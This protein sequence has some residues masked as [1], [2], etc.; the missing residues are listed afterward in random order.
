MGCAL[1][2]RAVSDVLKELEMIKAQVLRNI[3]KFAAAWP[4]CGALAYEWG[5]G[6]S[7]GL[8]IV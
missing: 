6:I 7:V 3:L 8:E 2:H 5:A 1:P 4:R